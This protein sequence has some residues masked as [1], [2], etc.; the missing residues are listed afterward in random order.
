MTPLQAARARQT[1]SLLGRTRPAVPFF[2]C[3]SDASGAPVLLLDAAEL[4]EDDILSIIST[5][6]RKRFVRGEV[7]RDDA[8]LLLFRGQGAGL[9]QLVTDLSGPLEDAVPGLKFAK[10]DVG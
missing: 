7:T 4:N 3:A 2:Y 9:A 5:A 10:V 6:R 8:G 1:L